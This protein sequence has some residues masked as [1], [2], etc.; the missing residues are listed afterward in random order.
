MMPMMP[1]APIVSISLEKSPLLRNEITRYV[2]KNMRAVPKSPILARH[3]R[4]NRENSMNPYRFF[5]LNRFSIV[6]APMQMNASLTI[7]DG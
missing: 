7:S 5:L 6:A 1:A 2:T 3:A 4:Q